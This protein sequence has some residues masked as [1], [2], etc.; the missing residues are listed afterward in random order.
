MHFRDTKSPRFDARH[1]MR[2]VVFHL[3]CEKLV[4]QKSRQ[5]TEL[6]LLLHIYRKNCKMFTAAAAPKNKNKS[7]GRFI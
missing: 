7:G 1:D 5:P 4:T 6:L 2:Q 3:Q